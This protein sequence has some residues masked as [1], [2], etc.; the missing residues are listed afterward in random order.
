MKRIAAPMVG[1]LAMSFLLELVV[2]PVLFTLWKR[3]AGFGRRSLKRC[4]VELLEGFDI[5]KAR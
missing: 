5:G 4:P 2:Y 3:P 1:G